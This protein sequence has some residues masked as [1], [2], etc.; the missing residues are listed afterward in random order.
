MTTTDRTKSTDAGAPALRLF[1]RASTRERFRLPFKKEKSLDLFLQA[2]QFEVENRCGKLKLTENVLMQAEKVVGFLT[3]ISRASGLLFCG[4]VGCGK[5]SFARAIQHLLNRL[6]MPCEDPRY[7]WKLTMM[8]A[9]QIA[10]LSRRE[11]K[12]WENLC[13][14]DMLAIDDIGRE[15]LDVSDFGNILNPIVDLLEYRYDKQL[16]TILTTNLTPTQI[17]ERYEERMADRF[18]EMFVKIIFRDPS[19]RP[20]EN[21][22]PEETSETE[23]PQ[24]Q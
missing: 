19:F 1:P 22:S 24:T 14:C 17:R 23:E 10:D 16:F 15:S 12:G 13:R 4:G 2:L 7:H 20:L 18:N 11:Y 6:N 8:T 3:T 9:R 5:T 21:V